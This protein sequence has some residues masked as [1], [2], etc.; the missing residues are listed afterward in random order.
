[1]SYI[2]EIGERN[3]SVRLSWFVAHAAYAKTKKLLKSKGVADITARACWNS[4]L[5]NCGTG[6]GF[7]IKEKGVER[8]VYF[9][10]WAEMSWQFYGK[11]WVDGSAC[12]NPYKGDDL[13]A[14]LLAFV[15][16]VQELCK[17]TEDKVCARCGEGKIAPNA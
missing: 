10:S 3:E 11:Y 7:E 5:S 4:S 9:H 8:G 17:E 16:A 13:A 6:L 2:N 15:S 12:T 1:M 14:A